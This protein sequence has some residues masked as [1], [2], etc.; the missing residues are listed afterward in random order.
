MSNEQVSRTFAPI[1]PNDD[2][3]WRTASD[4][5]FAPLQQESIPAVGNAIDYTLIPRGVV[6]LRLS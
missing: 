1:D 2:Q 3:M 4:R 5:V 6:A